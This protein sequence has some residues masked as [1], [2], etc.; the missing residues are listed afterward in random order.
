MALRLMV[1]RVPFRLFKLSLV[2]VEFTTSNNSSQKTS[3][4]STHSYSVPARKIINHWMVL[5]SLRDET[6]QHRRFFFFYF[7]VENLWHSNGLGPMFTVWSGDVEMDTMP[8]GNVVSW[9][10]IEHSWVE[11]S[12]TLSMLRSRSIV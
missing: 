7:T 2:V 8:F 5:G 1:V 4:L 3:I 6:I 9:F 10:C 11:I 12:P